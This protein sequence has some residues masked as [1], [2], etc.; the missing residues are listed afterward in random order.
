MMVKGGYVSRVGEVVVK[1]RQ[2]QHEIGI[3][4]EIIVF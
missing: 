4:N 3:V 1:K 2:V